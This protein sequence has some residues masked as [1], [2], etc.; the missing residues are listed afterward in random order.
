MY[1]PSAFREENPDVLVEFMRAHSFATL[2]STLDGVP[3][4]SHVPLSV[5]HD[6]GVVRLSGH[7]AKPNP[8]WRAFGN[9]ESLAI[10]AGPHAYVSPSLY[11]KRESVPTWNYIAVHAYG[12]PRILSQSGSRDALKAM[13]EALI[14]THEPAY[15]LQWDQL[16]EGFRDG[17][18]N[19]IV[20]FE[21]VVT[22]LE[23]KYKLSQ[24]RSEADQRRVALSLSHSTDPAAAAVGRAMQAVLGAEG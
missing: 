23:G 6:A 2:V 19:G 17:M 1:L 5:S 11:D 15:R 14:Q 13:L 3:T 21:I 12:T 18:I 4:A 24:N 22:R 20:G 7:L 16:P 9:G 10:F 8:Q